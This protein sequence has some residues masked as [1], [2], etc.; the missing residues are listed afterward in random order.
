MAGR[1]NGGAGRAHTARAGRGPGSGLPRNIVRRTLRRRCS[2]SIAIRHGRTCHG[3]GGGRQGR[4][5]GER[6]WKPRSVYEELYCTRGK[7]QNRIKEQLML[8]AD[9]T[10]AAWLR[11]DQTWLYFSSLTYVLMERLRRLGS[12]RPTSPKH[13]PRQFV[14]SR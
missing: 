3:L 5:F 6:R 10:S 12:N 11:R 14:R 2:V 13:R 4:A 9:C 1:F 7:M 8:F